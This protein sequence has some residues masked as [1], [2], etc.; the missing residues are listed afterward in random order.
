[1]K[2]LMGHK[3]TVLISYY[4]FL[5]L[6]CFF[7]LNYFIKKKKKFIIWLKIKALKEGSYV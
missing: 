6:I 7:L 3:P 4:K 1:M 2:I 5:N